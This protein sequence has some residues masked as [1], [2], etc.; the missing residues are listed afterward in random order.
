MHTPWTSQGALKYDAN[1]NANFESRVYNED[2]SPAVD[3]KNAPVY[4]IVTKKRRAWKSC[5]CR[6]F[7]WKWEDSFIWSWHNF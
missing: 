5:G 3:S 7:K 4:K 2:G 6:W 1:G